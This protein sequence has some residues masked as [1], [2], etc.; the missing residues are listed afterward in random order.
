MTKISFNNL[1]YL[2]L[3]G[4]PAFSSLVKNHFI[5]THCA[6]V[7]QDSQTLAATVRVTTKRLQN[8]N[9]ADNETVCLCGIMFAKS[10]LNC[11]RVFF[12]EIAMNLMKNKEQSHTGLEASI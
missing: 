12:K 4:V 2:F 8:L 6:Y 7:K 10:G 11:L 5:Y 3:N 9:D 1:I